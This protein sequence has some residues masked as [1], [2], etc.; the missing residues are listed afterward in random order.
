MNDTHDHQ[1]LS[2][3]LLELIRDGY[4][5]EFG[6]HIGSNVLDAIEGFVSRFIAFPNEHAQHAYVLWLAHT[7]LMDCWG[8]TP[9]LLFV[10]PEAGSGKTAALEVLEQLTPHADL[11]GNTTPAYFYYK[12]DESL[13]VDGARPTLLY[14]EIDTVFGPRRI[15][16]Q[17]ANEMR[18]IID[19]GSRRSGTIG[20][21]IGKTSHRFPVYAAMAMA[22]KML[23]SE[24]ADTIRTRS[25]VIPMQWAAPH[26]TVEYWDPLLSPPLAKPLRDMLSMWTEFVHGYAHEHPGVE[27]P[28]SIRNRDRDC[29]QPLLRVADLAGGRW[30][31]LA[32]VSAVSAVSASGVNAEPSEG[33]WLLWECRAIFDRRKIDAIH[34]TDLLDELRNTGRFRWTSKPAQ[35]AA[36]RLSQILRGYGVVPPTP[37]SRDQRIGGT[38]AKGY[39]AEW[40]EDTWQRYPRPE[41]A[42]TAETAAT[43]G[44][45]DD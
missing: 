45:S 27:V 36:I 33:L 37:A 25:I 38:K 35:E 43:N 15:R 6:Q 1:N 28:K 7:W 34:T 16:S 22:G 18:S 29:W 41:T 10:S 14:D 9:R 5:Y 8:T 2:A 17:S 24:V 13:E 23:A 32:T 31:A 19:N 44:Q 30:P 39:R 26:E 3:Q 21:R 4:D 40:F 11:T 42:E 12:I 20:R